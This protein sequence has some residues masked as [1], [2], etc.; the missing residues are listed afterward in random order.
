MSTQARAVLWD[1][2][3]TLLDSG[4]LH[5]LTW[6]EALA[7][8]NYSLTYDEFA[9][10]FGNRNDRFLRMLFGPD[11]SDAEI[12][13]ISSAKEVSYRRMVREGGSQLLPGAR[14][15][16]ETLQAQGW[17]QAI[18]SSAPRENIGVIMTV[19]QIAPYFGAIVA[20]EDVQQ[21]KPDPE[22]FLTAARKLGV[23]PARCVVVEDAPAGLEAGRAGG[24]RTI[25]VQTTHKHVEA[26][27]VVPALIDLPADAFSRL[28]PDS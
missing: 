4:E 23:E 14:H 5:W 28:V 18:G 8:E 25:G 13:R 10:G 24:M 12:A 22:V 15:W 3:G 11:M 1:L 17:Q 19:L 21:G 6:R 16:L 7:A 27:M 26:D 2:D 20:S 9:A